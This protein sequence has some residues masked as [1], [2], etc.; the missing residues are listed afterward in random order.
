M[1]DVNFIDIATRYETTF[2]ILDDSDDVFGASVA[3]L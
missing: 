1:G 2:N 3:I